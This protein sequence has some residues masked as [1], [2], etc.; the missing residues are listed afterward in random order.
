MLC[1]PRL[2]KLP[3]KFR[4]FA[5]VVFAATP[6]SMQESHKIK[7]DLILKRAYATK[8]SDLKIVLDTDK[9]PSLKHIASIDT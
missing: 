8:P 2:L 4:P 5:F 7:V 1:K 6:L 3:N 9:K